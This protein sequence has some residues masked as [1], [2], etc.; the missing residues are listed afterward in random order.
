[1]RQ[2]VGPHTQLAQRVLQALLERDLVA[3]RSRNSAIKLLERT[4]LDGDPDDLA[5]EIVR[6]LGR[7][8]VIDEIYT[9]DQELGDVIRGV[10]APPVAGTANIPGTGEYWL[11]MSDGFAHEVWTGPFPSPAAAQAHGW[12]SRE[13]IYVS[14]IR[15]ETGRGDEVI[16]IVG[17][18]T[19][20]LPEE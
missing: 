18:P 13:G 17:D 19:E 8:D 4:I 9:T 15:R 11:Q 10:L 2:F 5:G 20:G 12:T 7:D 16:R 1:M 3:V 14:V 6:F